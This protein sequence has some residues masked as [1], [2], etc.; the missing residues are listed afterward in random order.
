MI[1]AFLGWA[2][3]RAAVPGW[4]LNGWTGYMLVVAAAR[5]AI[6]F[7]YKKHFDESSILLWTNLIIASAASAGVGWAWVSLFV[8]VTPDPAYKIIIVMIILGIMAA[9]VPVLSALMTAFYCSS[10]PPALTL[11]A[12]MYSWDTSGSTFLVTALSI[13]IGLVTYTARN[14]NR[15]L[16]Q[17]LQLQREK[18]N[19]IENLN[20]EIAERTKAQHQ[21]ETH[22]QHLEETVEQRTRQLTQSNLEFED[23]IAERKRSEVELLESHARFTA[24]L[25]TLDAA[26]YVTDMKTYD[27]LFMNR[28]A[29]ERWGDQ[30]GKTCWKTLKLDQQG[31]CSYCTNPKLLD[32]NSQPTGVHLWEY[33]VPHTGRWL[34]CRDQA[35]RWPDGRLVRMEIATDITNR[36]MA[37]QRIREEHQFLQTIIDSVADP[38]MVVGLDRNVKLMNKAAT[39]ESSA[40]RTVSAKK[41]FQV[42]HGRCT[43]CSGL[44]QVCPLEAVSEMQKPVTVLHRHPDA[45][46]TERLYEVVGTPLFDNEHRLTGMVQASRDITAHIQIQEE[47]QENKAR[48]EHLAYHDALTSLPNRMLL[49]DRLHQAMTQTQQ[50]G[51]QLAVAYLDLDGFKEI[52]DSHDHGVGDQFL[53]ALARRMKGILRE[54]DTIARLGGDEFVSVLMDLEDAQDSIPLLNRLLFA[55]RQPVHVGDLVLQISGSVGVTIYP[56]SE[57]VDADQLLRQADHAMYKAKLTGKN[58]YHFFEEEMDRGLRG[59][60]ENM[61]SIRIGLVQ[62]EFV[63]HYQPKVNMRSGQVVGFEALIRWQH[64]ER[65]LL[66]PR[67]FLSFIEDD[68]LAIELDEW[69]VDTALSQIESWKSSGLGFSIS[70]NIGAY[71]L[72][73]KDFIE[74]LHALL[75]AHPDIEPNQL[76]LEVL[77]TSALDDMAKISEVIRICGAMGVLFALDDFGTGYSSLTY[78]KRLPVDF[79]KI[80]KSFVHDMLDDPED[81]A[82][83]EGVLGLAMAFG[84]QAIAE[85]VETKG[86]GEL[87]LRL[88]CELAQGYA[89]AKSM[90]ASDVPGWVEKWRPYTA[91][92][93]LSPVDRD[94]LPLLLAG[95]KHRAW[96]RSIEYYLLG[97]RPDLPLFDHRKCFFGTWLESTGLDRYG[98]R[99]N[100]SVVDQLHRQVHAQAKELCGDQG[101]SNHLPQ[102]AQF[103]ALHDLHDK[104]LREMKLLL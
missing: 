77:E 55:T 23:E 10:L 33:R 24:V 79:L 8:Q 66:M 64:P 87:L 99:D 27:V 103:D 51:A 17:T 101:Q 53:I 49:A 5:L 52:N 98:E 42:T 76:E 97:N 2:G 90:P 14:T 89:I 94:D 12:V 16:L 54:G 21:L 81:L 40:M 37:D 80:D 28:H 7:S 86:H 1:V 38:I 95:V 20:D 39:H 4:M 104:L 11:L 100:F 70:V 9:A 43:P 85:G 35:V 73:Q 82:I 96:I 63:L 102:R 22:R 15:I 13:Y 65:G 29:I 44:D 78:L 60:H 74:R 50:C 93:N 71:F 26:V 46:G 92:F 83:L 25:D 61:E 69:V 6:Y 58:R 91:W 75:E 36:V 34:E 45:D 57:E 31:P 47:L 88:G 62:R 59:R 18:E 41:C 56:Q 67:T 84:R 48:L 32:V 3:L 72:Q 30:V 68:P 19:L